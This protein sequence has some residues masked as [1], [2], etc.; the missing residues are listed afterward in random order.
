MTIKSILFIFSGTESELYALN[1]AMT[2]AKSYAAHLR[3]LHITPEVI[4][5]IEGV[6]TDAAVIEA[7]EEDNKQRLNMARQHTTHYTTM[8]N[9]PLDS[10]TVPLHHASAQFFSLTGSPEEL[11]AAEGRLCDLIIIGREHDS[12]GAPYDDSIVASLFNTGRPVMLIPRLSGVMPREWHSRTVAIAWNGSLESSRALYNAMPFM[13]QAEKV[14]I[15]YAREHNEQHPVTNEKGIMEYM[16]AHGIACDV[17]ITDR[18]KLGTAETLL[19]KA[20]QLNSDMLVMGAY[21]H[22][23]FREMVLGGVTN[24][25]L[26]HCKIPLFLSH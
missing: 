1:T 14:H 16:T 9:I 13:E 5:Y 26:D 10:E 21:G 24:H 4:P 6:V 23:R 18:E 25:M 7:I 19:A 15:L 3:I 17:I 22:T 11:V 2:L 8:H 12:L 20:I